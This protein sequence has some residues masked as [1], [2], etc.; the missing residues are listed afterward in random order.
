MLY[1]NLFSCQD[2][3]AIIT[4][5]TGLI[6]REIVK[7]L[8]EFGALVYIADIN[9]KGIKEVIKNTTIKYVYLDISSENSIKEA[10]TNIMLDRGRIDILVNCAYPR[11]NDIN[12][13][14]E[15]VTFNLWKRNVQNHLGGYFLV[16]QKVAEHMKQQRGGIIINL[17]SIYGVVAPDFSIYDGTDMT[18]PVA[19]SAIKAGIIA[20]TKYI[21]TY[22]AKYNIRANTISPGGIFNNQPPSFVEKYSNKTPIKRMGYPKEV[23]G[24]VIYLASD[25]SSYVTGQNLMVDGGWTTW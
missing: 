6:G 18:M 25:A 14:F 22:Y 8:Y 5:G 24:A 10:I 2:K 16:C 4:G 7:G 21:A 1:K 9:K 20:F 23:V 3:V 13:K 17:A 15:Q 12:L 19:Y 11:A